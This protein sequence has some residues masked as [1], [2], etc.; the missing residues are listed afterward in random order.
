MGRYLVSEGVSDAYGLFARGQPF[1]GRETL[2]QVSTA[3]FGVAGDRLTF[4]S[5]L[6]PSSVTLVVLTPEA[7]ESG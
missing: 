3:S 7:A 6:P 4:G 1:D 2:Q 5:A